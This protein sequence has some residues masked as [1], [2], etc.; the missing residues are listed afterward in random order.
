MNAWSKNALWQVAATC[1]SSARRTFPDHVPLYFFTL[2]FAVTTS[3]L[4]AIYHLSFPLESADFF[5]VTIGEAI[6]LVGGFAALRHLFVLCR[7]GCPDHPLSIMVWRLLEA[8]ISGDRFGNLLHGLIAFTPLMMMFAALKVDITEI[9]PFAWDATFMRWGTEMGFGRPF[10]QILQPALGHPLIT[11]ILSMAYGCW[12]PVM[13]GCLFWQLSRTRSDFLRSQYLLAFAFAWFFGGFVIA[14]IFSSAGPCF[15]SH[16][17]QGPNPYA[18]LLAYLRETRQHWP[19]W[20][21]DA[22]DNLWQAYVTGTGDIQGISA[23]PSMHVM[24]ATLMALLGWRVNRYVGLGLTVF[25]SLVFLSSIM[26][27]WHYSP[28]GLV[29]AALALVFWV[30]AGH[31]VRAWTAFRERPVSRGR[32]FAGGAALG[33]A[34]S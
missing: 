12:F 25:G 31:V 6:L 29:G 28:D 5:L 11:T 1:A 23:M 7:R 20:T 33:V 3:A 15:Y 30:L 21:V 22:Q 24:I 4:L 17:V 18:P 19:I 32:T 2:L 16:F 34:E 14:T 26:L 13:F 27:G 10:W 8:A 9:H